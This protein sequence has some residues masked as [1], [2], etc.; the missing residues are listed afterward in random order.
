MA[1]SFS[2]EGSN[3]YS[4]LAIFEGTLYKINFERQAY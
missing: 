4:N 1:V 3:L 2:D